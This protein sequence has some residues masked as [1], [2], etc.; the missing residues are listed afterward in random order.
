MTTGIVS[1]C[2]E[3]RLVSGD[4]W[5]ARRLD[6]ERG[7]QE[8]AECNKAESVTLQSAL[9]ACGQ[10]SELEAK[11]QK[12]DGIENVY[13]IPLSDPETGLS[14]RATIY[15]YGPIRPAT[16]PDRQ[17]HFLRQ[18]ETAITAKG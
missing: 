10:Q 16:E 12:P 5:L 3:S 2:T 6:W 8:I 9:A 15:G 7:R 17:A 13:K 11:G 4:K 1:G 14:F 18:I